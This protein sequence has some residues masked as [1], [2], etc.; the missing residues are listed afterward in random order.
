MSKAAP[1]SPLET[2]LSRSTLIRVSPVL[3]EDGEVR[4]LPK[5]C[6]HLTTRHF[7]FNNA[8]S[9]IV[10]RSAASA[11]RRRLCTGAGASRSRIFPR[12]R[13]GEA[14]CVCR[15]VFVEYGPM[16][17]DLN[18]RVRV[19]FLEQALAS[20][21]RGP[22]LPPLLSLSPLSPAAGCLSLRMKQT[23]YGWIEAVLPPPFLP[24]ASS[25]CS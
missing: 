19:H 9:D 2:A 23:E 18:L 22:P 17:L 24:F 1:L 7:E 15:Y 25:P 6:S 12:K 5:R 8:R 10:I 20:Q 4:L 21:A 13:D 14:P 16:Q 3:V 11:Y